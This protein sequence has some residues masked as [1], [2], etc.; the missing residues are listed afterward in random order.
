MTRNNTS[1]GVTEWWYDTYLLRS[2]R[3]RGEWFEGCWICSGLDRKKPKLRWGESE[4]LRNLYR[5]YFYIPICK[6]ISP[7]EDQPFQWAYSHIWLPIP[8]WILA[9][10]SYV[11]YANFP[12]R[13]VVVSPPD[14]D[15]LGMKYGPKSDEITSEPIPIEI[16]NPL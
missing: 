16:V 15:N 12:C 8:I 13:L 1:C 3:P 9:H 11:G 2:R 7:E 14:R 6:L 4:S 10:F 5:R